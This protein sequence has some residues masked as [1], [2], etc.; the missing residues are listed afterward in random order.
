VDRGV[1]VVAGLGLIPPPFPFTPFVLASGALGMKRW[2]FLAALAGVRAFRF[3]I[4]AA[5]ASQYGSGILRWMKTP[6]FQVTVGVFI[7]LAVV[8]TIV[9][10][11]L[12]F[13]GSKRG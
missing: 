10:A 3:G 7:A 8:G 13:R 11:V 6:A 2:S 5:L 9:S 1:F 12:V 4:E